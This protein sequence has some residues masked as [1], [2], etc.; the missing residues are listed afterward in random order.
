MA[1]LVSDEKEVVFELDS[2]VLAGQKR[3]RLFPGTIAAINDLIEPDCS[4]VNGYSKIG[5]RYLDR[6]RQCP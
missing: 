1:A 5:I 2:K 3:N 4:V 6:P